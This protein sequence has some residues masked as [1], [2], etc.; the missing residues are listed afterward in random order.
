MGAQPVSIKLIALDPLFVTA[1]IGMKGACAEARVVW[2]L[3]AGRCI[4]ASRATR[5]YYGFC[6]VVT[7]DAGLQC[8][9]LFCLVKFP[10]GADRRWF[11]CAGLSIC[12]LR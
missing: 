6:V 11:L 3:L 2:R 7:L 5:A 1:C 10:R 8:K 12:P 9:R 4:A